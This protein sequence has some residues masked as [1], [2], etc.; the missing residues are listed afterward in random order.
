MRV[1][2]TALDWMVVP[3]LYYVCESE[4]SDEVPTVGSTVTVRELKMEPMNEGIPFLWAQ[5]LYLIARLT[6]E[7]ILNV[8]VY[9][10]ELMIIM[11]PG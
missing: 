2:R 6:R 11:N 8:H 7:L 3:R 9:Y 10:Q 4:L 1:S 5:A